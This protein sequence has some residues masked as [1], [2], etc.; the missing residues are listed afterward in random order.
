[1][2]RINESMEIGCVSLM[3]GGVVAVGHYSDID[4]SLPR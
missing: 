3:H 1:M 2:N 4:S